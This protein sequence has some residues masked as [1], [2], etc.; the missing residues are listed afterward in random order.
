[1]L[2]HK[3]KLLL[4]GLLLVSAGLSASAADAPMATSSGKMIVHEWGTF[5]S[6]Q[7]S[8]GATLGGMVDSEEEL[9]NFVRERDLWGGNRACWLQKMETPVTYFYVDTPR[10]IQVKVGMP[11]GLLT[12]WYPAVRGFGPPIQPKDK[13][14]AAGAACKLSFLDWGKVELIPDYRSLGYSLTPPSFKAVDDRSTWR[15]ARETDSAFVKAPKSHPRVNPSSTGEWEKF[16]F[17]RGLGSFDL[18]LQVRSSGPAGDVR[19]ALSNRGHTALTGA[20]LIQVENGVLRFGALPDLAG[21]T[22][23]EH[24]L[25]SILSQPLPL[26]DGVAPAKQ[27]VEAALVKAGLYSKEARAMVNTWEKS[28]FRTDGLRV[29]YV[30]PR[31]LTDATI[32]IQVQPAPDELVRVMVGRVEVLTPATEA[33]IEK[34][35]ADLAS[36]NPEA[37]KAAAAE[38][39]RLGRL[40]EPVL[41][42]IEAMTQ[43]PQVRER[44]RELIRRGP[45]GT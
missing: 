28:Y 21:D 2:R 29:L 10:T 37:R 24:A 6:V 11:G 40:E 16:L 23:R 32:P 4:L 5:L 38:L 30:L 26:K 25:A 19:L 27:A 43:A 36:P 33:R 12:H 8:D 18:P 1:M 39:A 42:R 31:S 14:T 34:A 35:V 3:G 15:F 9:P 7:G 20:F 13:P 44:A 17:Y 45:K 41:H 22:S